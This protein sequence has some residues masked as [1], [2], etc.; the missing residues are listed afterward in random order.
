MTEL[1][2]RLIKLLLG[3]P[4][5]FTPS[6]EEIR[7]ALGLASRSQVHSLVT[8]MCR[9]GLVSREPHRARSLR[10]VE[11]PDEVLRQRQRLVSAGS[12]AVYALN[13]RCQAEG[14]VPTLEEITDA[15][16]ELAL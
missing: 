11:Q 13:L 4:H 15:L 1:Q 6:Y 3:Q 5:G 8:S 10:V 7:I 16:D 14:R 2:S 9:Q 12:R